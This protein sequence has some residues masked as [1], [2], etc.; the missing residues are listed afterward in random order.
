MSSLEFLQKYAARIEYTP[1][2]IKHFGVKNADHLR[3]R[4]KDVL[5]VR[6]KIEGLKKRFDEN[7]I[8]EIKN[9][10]LKGYIEEEEKFCAEHHISLQNL[11]ALTRIKKPDA[12]T[13]AGLR[14]EIAKYKI[15]PAIEL[16][17][18]K[19]EDGPIIVYTYFRQTQK[20]LS[21]KSKIKHEII[22]GTTSM[23]RRNEIVQAY[24]KGEVSLLLASIGA[25]REGV[26]LTAG[27]I[28]VFLEHDW[29]P[30]NIEQAI[31]RL[32]RRGQNQ[33]VYVYHI[34]FN[35]GI[36]LYLQRLLDQKRKIIKQLV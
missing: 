24:Q 6:K 16:I 13:I 27:N 2:G 20:I 18:N 14:Q 11:E 4:L 17:K 30:A 12:E 9:E 23:K 5:L 15:L 3:A 26:N 32:Y 19:I 33:D 22:N 10:K 28:V 1:W 29:T 36:D 7:I 34:F 8:L 35:A 31:G 25:L 21:E